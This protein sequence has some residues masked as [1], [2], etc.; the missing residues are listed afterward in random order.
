[1]CVKCFV[2]NHNGHDIVGFAKVVEQKK[3][4]ITKEIQ[5]TESNIL[6][7][8]QT[9]NDDIKAQI[10]KVNASFM[11]IKTD[12]ERLRKLWHQEANAIFNKGNGLVNS[13]K[14]FKSDGQDW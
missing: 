9:K 4:T 3:E 13:M 12:L 10:G 5:E 8:Y 11:N 7:K 14:D 6:P 2:R 1:M